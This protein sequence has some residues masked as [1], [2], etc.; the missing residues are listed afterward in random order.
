MGSEKA[1]VAQGG[2]PGGWGENEERR[3]FE[4]KWSAGGVGEERDGS[5]WQ[6]GRTGVPMERK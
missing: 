5:G 1:E 3:N 6:G 4:A 2:G